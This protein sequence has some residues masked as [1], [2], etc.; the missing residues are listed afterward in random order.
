MKSRLT[1]LLFLAG[2]SVLMPAHA[3]MGGMGP[4]MGAGVEKGMGMGPGMGM[5]SGGKMARKAP[6]CGQTPDPAQC[7]ARRKHRQE[8]R[9]K[10]QAQCKDSVGPERRK[11][12]REIMMAQ[13]DCSKTQN[14]T[15]CAAMKQ[16]YES[17][18]EKLG[19]DF[20]ACMNAQ[21]PTGQPNPTPESSKKP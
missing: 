1:A 3:Q 15:R 19:P 12:V 17:C 7:E 6:A 18:K 2:A 4:G 11:C 5:S 10:A 20:R 14:P 16:T 8:T 9:A 13:E 21:A